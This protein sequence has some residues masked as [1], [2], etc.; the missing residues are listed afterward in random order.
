M[1]TEGPANNQADLTKCGC[2]RSY[3]CGQK[4]GRHLETF[5]LGSVVSFWN[6]WKTALCRL[7]NEWGKKRIVEKKKEI[8]E[9]EG[10]HEEHFKRLKANPPPRTVGKKGSKNRQ[11][12]TGFSEREREGHCV[13]ETSV[14][15][16]KQMCQDSC[17]FCWH[18]AQGWHV[19]HTRKGITK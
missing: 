15:N 13:L 17:T 4:R 7:H 10:E 2:T 11:H 18:F 8:K 5:C 9:M 6:I 19:I 12:E 3:G 14:T 1:L 16:H